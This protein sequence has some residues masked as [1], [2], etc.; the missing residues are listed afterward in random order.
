MGTQDAW[1]CDTLGYLGVPASFVGECADEAGGF[2]PAELESGIK[3]GMTKAQVEAA[4]GKVL[5]SPGGEACV[6]LLLPY[7]TPVQDHTDGW[8]G[9]TLRLAAISARPGM[10][11][12]ERIGLG[13]SRAKVEAAYPQGSLQNG[14]WTVPL[15]HGTEY[16]FGI[17]QDGTVGE[18]LLTMTQNGCTE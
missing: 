16:R 17:E 13:S 2:G 6:G 1:D 12:P 14:Y 11:T 9:T 7:Q 5:P 10:K 15:G 8:F 3:L 4:G 18:M